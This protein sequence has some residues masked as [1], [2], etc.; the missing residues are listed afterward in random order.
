M[1]KDTMEAK[2][3][4]SLKGRGREERSDVLS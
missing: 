1:G 4:S 2:G 3:V